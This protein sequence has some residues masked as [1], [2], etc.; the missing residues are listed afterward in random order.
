MLRRWC[1]KINQKWLDSDFF[2]NKASMRKRAIEEYNLQ[3]N[4]NANP[5]VVSVIEEWSYD[6]SVLEL[7][8]YYQ[9]G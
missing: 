8:V 2:E 5:V 7:T 6:N 4:K 1:V 9:V 3:I